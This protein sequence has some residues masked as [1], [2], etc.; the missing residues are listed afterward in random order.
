[1]L[2]LPNPW[3]LLALV[4]L[5]LGTGGGMYAKGHH[6]AMNSNQVAYLKAE[7]KV[8]TEA[9][10]EANR[11][12]AATHVDLVAA[13]ERARADALKAE[14]DAKDLDDY[15]DQVAKLHDACDAATDVDVQW[16]RGGSPPTKRAP[17]APPPPRRP[18]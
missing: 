1:M 18:G 4:G 10:Q 14:Q 8:L 6:D 11:Q 13:N 7:K 2:G 17:I 5:L 9:L 12:M 15:S 16:M 3:V